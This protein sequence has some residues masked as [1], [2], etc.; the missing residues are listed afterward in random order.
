[1]KHQMDNP[2]RET[3]KT[4]IQ[5]SRGKDFKEAE[6]IVDEILEET[7]GLQ[8]TLPTRFVELFGLVYFGLVFVSVIGLVLVWSSF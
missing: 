6:L 3:L 8:L 5:N 4:A 7:S 1:M 2:K